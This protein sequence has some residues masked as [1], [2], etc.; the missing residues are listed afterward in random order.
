MTYYRL[1]RDMCDAKEGEIYPG[2]QMGGRF[3]DPD[4][5]EFWEE[6]RPRFMAGNLVTARDPGNMTVYDGKTVIPMDGNTLAKIRGARLTV[7]SAGYH[8]KTWSFI[9]R[10]KAP[11]VPYTLCAREANLTALGQEKKAADTPFGSFTDIKD[12][13][14]GVFRDIFR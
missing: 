9:Y 10:L 12:A 11:G 4:N 2:D 13:F 3:M 1:L 14:G 7:M 5:D 8:R 6:A